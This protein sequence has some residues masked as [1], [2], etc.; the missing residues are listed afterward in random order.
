[1]PDLIDLIGR[2]FSSDGYGRNGYNCWTLAM[3]V[4]RRYGIEIEEHDISADA[5]VA[6]ACEVGRSV[7][8][9]R[10]GVSHWKPCGYEIPALVA[11]K[12]HISDPRVVNHV[13][14]TVPGPGRRFIQA[15]RAAGV[16]YAHLDDPWI[17]VEGFYRYAE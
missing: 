1:M 15:T 2:P 6:V 9:A 7:R 3:E 8:A 11:I 12:C 14:V 4:F 10:S 16:H 5:S 17:R 13:G